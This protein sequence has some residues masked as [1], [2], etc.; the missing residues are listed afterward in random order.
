[1]EWIGSTCGGCWVDRG[2]SAWDRGLRTLHGHAAPVHWR[3]DALTS[4]MGHDR[5]D[6]LLD[7]SRKRRRADTLVSIGLAAAN[8]I[9]F[10][11]DQLAARGKSAPA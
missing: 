3:Q 1:M 6:L 7:V 11:T 8:A 5:P 4:R 9:L 2:I 10:E